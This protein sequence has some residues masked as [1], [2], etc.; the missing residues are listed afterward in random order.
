MRAERIESGLQARAWSFNR[1]A[2]HPVRHFVLLTDGIGGCETEGTRLD[3]AAPT[4][5]WLGGMKRG[6]LR[7]EAGATGFR[8]EAGDEMISAAVGE[9]PESAG[10]QTLANRDFVLSL[11]GHGD[12][13]ALAERCLTRIVEELRLGQDGAALAISGLLRILLVVLL[14][15]S[16]GSVMDRAGGGER[17]GV[18][19]RFRRLVEMNF[20]SHWSVAQYAEALGISADRLHAI[21]TTGVGRSPK[22]LISERLA[23][24]AAVRLQRSSLTI[25]QLG[26]TLGFNDPAHFSH[27]FRRMMGVSPAAYR[28]AAP[29][30][31]TAGSTA[32]SRT[33]ADWP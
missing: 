25:Q 16:G 15:V 21:C 14:R 19:Q 4:I 28:R 23:Q 30:A 20:R 31:P 1:E 18:L 26:H 8:G 24:E 11:A 22:A 5:L 13:A 17:T 3:L 27:F 2:D 12:Q 6:R 10:L 33:F 29:D 7:I 9:Q 32:P